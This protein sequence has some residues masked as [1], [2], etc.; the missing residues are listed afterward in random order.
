[1]CFDYSTTIVSRLKVGGVIS[2]QSI[3]VAVSSYIELV[4]LSKALHSSQC[5]NLKQYIATLCEQRKV[6]LKEYLLR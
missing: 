4:S 2:N 6:E 5:S 3:E 1:M